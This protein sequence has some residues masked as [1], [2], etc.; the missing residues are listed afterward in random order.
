MLSSADGIG[1]GVDVADI[2][3]E[4]CDRADACVLRWALR[5]AIVDDPE[6]K[7]DFQLSFLSVVSC[8]RF[9][10]TWYRSFSHPTLYKI[11]YIYNL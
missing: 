8:V 2:T 5:N 7:Q 1:V 4:I 6:N 10:T 11:K 3:T 9:S